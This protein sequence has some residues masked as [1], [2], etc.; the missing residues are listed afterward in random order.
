[1][2]FLVVVCGMGFLLWRL[3]IAEHGLWGVRDSV[4]GA[5][6]LHSCVFLPLEHRLSNCGTWAFLLRG[7]QNLGEGHGNPLQK[8]WVENPMDRGAWW[9]VVHG[10]TKSQTRLK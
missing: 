9:A 6:G 5:R 8:S 1:M 7:M 4:T 2:W 10:I 3:L